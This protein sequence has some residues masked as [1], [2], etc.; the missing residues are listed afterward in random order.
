VQEERSGR[1][2]GAVRRGLVDGESLAEQTDLERAADRRV[3][4][5]D[6]L[7]RRTDVDVRASGDV[8]YYRVTIT[9]VRR[10]RSRRSRRRRRCK[11]RCGLVRHHHLFLHLQQHQHRQPTSTLCFHETA[12]FNGI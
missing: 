2:N 10:R 9:H 3:R 5:A 11:R 7:G 8:A 6:A 1:W 12:P 4:M